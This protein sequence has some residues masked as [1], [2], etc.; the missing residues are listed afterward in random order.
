MH[1]SSLPS[2]AATATLPPREAPDLLLTRGPPASSRL[3]P[4]DS[5]AAAPA[6]LTRYITQDRDRIAQGINDV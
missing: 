6:E 5:G 1:R 3:A 2:A 4:A